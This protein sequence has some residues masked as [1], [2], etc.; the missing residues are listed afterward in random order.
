MG[1][2]DLLFKIRRGENQFYSKAKKILRNI[3]FFDFPAP[4]WIFRPLYEGMIVTRFLIRFI[5][6]KLFYIPI[7]KARCVRCGKG[8]S[9]PNGIP[10]IEGN[11]RIE[12]GNN[13]SIDDNVFVSGHVALNPALIVGDRTV[14]G[15]KVSISV[16]KK[17]EIGND[18]LIA[19]GCLIADNN[20]HSVD[21]YRRLRKEPV[22]E[23]E[24]KPV[25]IE[26]N[27]WIG[28][29]AV[30][31]KGVTVGTGSVV[32]A[33][34]VVTRSVPPNSVAMGIPAKVVS[35]EIDKMNEAKTSIIEE[36]IR[37][38]RG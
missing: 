1:I 13:V 16:G 21:P 7:F 18:V 17:V 15:Y 5:P 3:I 9:L 8:L 30:I 35:S 10:W 33:N 38:E 2:E 11:L 25:K 4:K 12:I 6:E 34:S 31:L 28:T 26:D 27:A 29:R 22:T 24:I 37:S 14:L 20:G 23:D 32:A 36:V 19:S